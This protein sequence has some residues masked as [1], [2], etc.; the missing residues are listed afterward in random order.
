M[1]PQKTF[2]N[3]RYTAKLRV[4][5]YIS[6]SL[7]FGIPRDFIGRISTNKLSLSMNVYRPVLVDKLG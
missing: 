4:G 3:I 5:G 7:P 2:R 6:T 1:L